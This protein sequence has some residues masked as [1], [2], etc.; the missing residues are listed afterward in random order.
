M[1][2]IGAYLTLK[3]LIAEQTLTASPSAVVID[4]GATNNQR[5]ESVAF[6]MFV[7]AGGITFSAANYI[8]LKL[9][10]SDDNV[11]FANVLAP[12]VAGQGGGGVVLGVNSGASNFGQSP[13]AN[14]FVRLINAAKA[15]ADADPF[16][17]SYVGSKRYVRSTIV[18]G[19]TH[20]T[21]TLVGLWAVL[22]YPDILP[23]A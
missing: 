14:G 19:G 6:G 16:K 8:A 7:G 22:G 13:D 3:R 21:G 17:V 2:D 4:R 20:A 5:S 12:P 10:D 18:F 15:A 11:T 1:R 23:A 9:E